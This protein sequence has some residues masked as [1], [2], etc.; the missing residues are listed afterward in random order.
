MIVTAR[1]ISSSA[2]GERRRHAQAAGLAAGAAAHEVNGESAPLALVR[3]RQ[4]E[5]IGRLTRVAILDELEAAEQAD[6]ADVPDV[7]VAL[8]QLAQPAQQVLAAR[9]RPLREPLP[10]DDV[11]DGERRGGRHGVRDMRGHGDEAAR[12]ASSMPRS[13]A[14]S[15]SRRK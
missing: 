12:V 10:L 1:S 7:L 9:A 4:P 15:A 13:L 8:L 5:R 6:A 11:D 2:N 3:E 14:S